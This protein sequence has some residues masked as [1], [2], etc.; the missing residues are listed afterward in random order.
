MLYAGDSE[1]RNQGWTQGNP[2]LTYA[3]PQLGSVGHAT[4]IAN[5]GGYH[6]ATRPDH[7]P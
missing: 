3:T 6:G 5:K 7:R 4:T 2:H 1:G